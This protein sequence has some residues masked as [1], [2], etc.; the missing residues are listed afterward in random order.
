MEE[1]A[2]LFKKEEMINQI[3]Y[4]ENEK[5]IMEKIYD[6]IKWKTKPRMV[7]I[8]LK[9]AQFWSILLFHQA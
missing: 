6:V 4:G 7:F 2:L 1:I 3:I 5:N 9:Y 8:F